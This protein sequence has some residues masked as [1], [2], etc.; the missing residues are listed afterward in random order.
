M[1][2]PDDWEGQREEHFSPSYSVCF[3]I[4][5]ARI[6]ALM[7]YG[8]EFHF[9]LSVEGLLRVEHI[10]KDWNLIIDERSGESSLQDAARIWFNWSLQQTLA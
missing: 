1:D 5:L 6:F 2:F 9:R 7:I 3:P 8:E 4:A 10:K